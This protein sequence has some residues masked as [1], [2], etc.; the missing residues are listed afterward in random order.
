MFEDRIGPRVPVSLLALLLE[1]GELSPVVDLDKHLP[2]DDESDA[3]GVDKRK[4]LDDVM[5]LRNIEEGLE[6][7]GD[8]NLG[9]TLTTITSL[10]DKS[11]MAIKDTKP[12]KE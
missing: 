10:R 4:Q 12:F 3:G 7:R 8:T 6:E 5:L 1:L 11:L 2:H 9:W